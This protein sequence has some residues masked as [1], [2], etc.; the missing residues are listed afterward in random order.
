MSLI[1]FL[2]SIFSNDDDKVGPRNDPDVYAK[3]EKRT[4]VSRSLKDGELAKESPRDSSRRRLRS[5]PNNKN[6]VVAPSEIAAQLPGISRINRRGQKQLIIGLDFGTAFTK[7]VVGEDRFK[8]AIPLIA[9]LSASVAPEVQTISLGSQLTK[10]ATWDR[11]S[12]TASSAC[13]PNL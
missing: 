6:Q 11:A 9:R 5:S 13:H 1:R 12:S 4:D 3:K 10:L 7:V 8:L 2:K